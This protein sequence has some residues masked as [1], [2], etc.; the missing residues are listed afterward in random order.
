[1]KHKNFTL[2]PYKLG[3]AVIKA[4]LLGKAVMKNLLKD[5]SLVGSQS[6]ESL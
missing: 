5:F 4:L 3:D 1:M 2:K 6:F